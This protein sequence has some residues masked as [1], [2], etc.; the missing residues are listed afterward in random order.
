[1][2]RAGHTG[3][4]AGLR[5][6]YFHGAIRGAHSRGPFGYCA[7]QLSIMSGPPQKARCEAGLCLEALKRRQPIADAIS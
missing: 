4:T 6:P 7:L 5:W 1:M 3:F 2:W